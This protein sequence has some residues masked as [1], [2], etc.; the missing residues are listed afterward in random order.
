VG[1]DGDDGIVPGVRSDLESGFFIP[2][3][4]SVMATGW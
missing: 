4:T 2:P 3:V 1:G